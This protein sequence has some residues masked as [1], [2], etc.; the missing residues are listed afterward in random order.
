MD[1]FTIALTADSAT[2]RQRSTSPLFF[3]RASLF[4]GSQDNDSVRV[5]EG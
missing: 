3:R 1:P 5:V 2:A 4:P